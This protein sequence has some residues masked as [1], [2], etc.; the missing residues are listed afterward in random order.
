MKEDLDISSDMTLTELKQHKKSIEEMNDT[1]MSNLKKLNNILIDKLE[2]DALY[3]NPNLAHHQTKKLKELIETLLNLMKQQQELQNLDKANSETFK[4]L[5]YEHK[6][7]VKIHPVE[8][9]LE[10]PIISSSTNTVSAVQM[11]RDKAL[12]LVKVLLATLKSSRMQSEENFTKL[13]YSSDLMFHIMYKAEDTF[14]S[15]NDN[16]QK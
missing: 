13:K 8:R 14:L 7:L 10:T 1:S 4:K 6:D 9:K 12:G 16:K 11:E 15:H 3:Q 2:N 5:Y